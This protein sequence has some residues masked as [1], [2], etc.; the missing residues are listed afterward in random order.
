MVTGGTVTR[1]QRLDK[2]SNT[3]WLITVVPD[4]N[5]AVTVVLPTIEDC[6]DVRA[7]CTAMGKM[8]STQLELTVNGPSG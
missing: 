6:N 5:A 4:T 3:R 1:V 2:P 7:I 8:L